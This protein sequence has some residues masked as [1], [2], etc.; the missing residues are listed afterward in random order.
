MLPPL[1]EFDLVT[2]GTL[3]RSPSGVSPGFFAKDYG[4]TA[5]DVARSVDRLREHGC[6][7]DFDVEAGPR[8][9]RSGLGVWG[10]YLH[11]VLKVETGR[12]R[13]VEVYRTLASTQ[14]A[15]KR[16]LTTGGER[17]MVLA[18]EQT[19]G[20]GRHGRRW[21]ARPGEAVLM[22]LDTPLDPHE[23]GGADRPS[24]AAAVA[25]AEVVERLTG[26]AAGGVHIKPPND[27]MVDGRKLAGIL[28]ET[29]TINVG[30][31]VAVIGIGLNIHPPPDP[32]DGGRPATSLAD[33]GSPY[34][35]L[36]VAATLLARLQHHL[37]HTPLPLLRDEWRI[38]LESTPTNNSPSPTSP[39]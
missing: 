8:L 32:Q 14:D 26:R 7:I 9:L 39:S 25:I 24:L 11:H 22:S 34:D 31:R 3:V 35:R 16:R 13:R 29:L 17:I 30:R 37:T 5:S 33:L 38:R 21:L 28:I 4:A 10:E 23:P 15:V 20:R 12:E 2:L 1:E 18:D 36:H 19:A 27:V 6:V